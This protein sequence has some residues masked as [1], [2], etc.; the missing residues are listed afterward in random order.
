M[1]HTACVGFGLERIALALYRQHGF[2]RDTW[3][4]SVREALGPVKLRLWDLD[5]AAYGRHPLHSVDRAWPESNCYVDLWVELLHAAGADPLAAL[6][7]ALAVDFEGDQWTFFKF[8]LAD[9]DALYGVD[10]FE[11]NVWRSAA[12]P[13][14]RAARAGAARRSSKWTRSTCRTRPAPPTAREHVKTSIAIQALD[15]ED[16]RLGYFHNAG[17]Y[18]LAGDDFAGV[19]RLEGHLTDPE[20]LPPYVEVAKFGNRP[21]RTGRALRRRLARAASRAPR[22]AARDEPIPAIR[23]TISCRSGVARRRAALV[24]P[25]LRLRH[26]AAVRRRI[27]ARRRLPPLARGRGE[28]GLE[29]RGRSLRA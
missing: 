16:R 9:L 11:L 7:F 27:R 13:R 10:V 28:G 1:A 29:S 6:P 8:P 5:P 23:R 26:A 25:Q 2:D 24:L 15:L 12:G 4:S 19:F 17:Y 14:C 3:P 20:Y 18:E 22:A 21:P